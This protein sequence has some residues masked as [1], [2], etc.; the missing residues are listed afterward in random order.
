MS[1]AQNV[2]N[3]KEGFPL[4]QFTFSRQLD[5]TTSHS[6]TLAISHNTQ[7]VIER[8]GKAP[9]KYKVVLN[10]KITS[11]DQQVR[12]TIK[13]LLNQVNEVLH[14]ETKVIWTKVDQI[15]LWIIVGYDVSD[16]GSDPDHL[17]EMLDKR[18]DTM[19]REIKRFLVTGKTS[20][21][22]RHSKAIK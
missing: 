21:R 9:A 16:L 13:E 5:S 15:D 11:K 1:P 8:S 7:E 19:L 6:F 14:K 20:Y 12:E 3:K 17:S 22:L 2:N 4:K 10:F 18:I